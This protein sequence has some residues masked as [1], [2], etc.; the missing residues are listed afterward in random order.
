MPSDKDKKKDPLP[1]EKAFKEANRVEKL[2]SGLF[3]RTR[4]LANKL[5][6]TLAKQAED[7]DRL[8]TDVLKVGAG[9]V[10][11]FTGSGVVLPVGRLI[12]TGGACKGTSWLYKKWAG[13]RGDK[14]AKRVN[15]LRQF[16]E[17]RIEKSRLAA[18]EAQPSM[19]TA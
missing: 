1:G 15:L 6:L 5:K 7:T 3:L 13:W 12:L 2:P 17:F 18:E 14:I 19:G 9:V 10:L 16:H 11:V 4:I 8:V